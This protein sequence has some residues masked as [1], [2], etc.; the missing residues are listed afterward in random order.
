M[1]RQLS[2][3]MAYP[4]PLSCAM[5][6]NRKSVSHNIGVNIGITLVAV[7]P[8]PKLWSA[9][10]VETEDHDMSLIRIVAAF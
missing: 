3:S 9:S 10:T 1:A 8:R 6:R 5:R 2:C 4:A 7:M